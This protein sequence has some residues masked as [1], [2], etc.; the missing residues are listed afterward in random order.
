MNDLVAIDSD[1]LHEVAEWIATQAPGVTVPAIRAQFTLSAKQA[2][3]AVALA[4]VMRRSNGGQ[5]S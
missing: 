5:A 1:K 3:E 4:V 2:C